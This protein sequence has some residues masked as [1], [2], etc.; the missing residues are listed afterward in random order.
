[1]R[2]LVSLNQSLSGFDAV[3]AVGANRGVATI[4]KKNDM[5]VSAIALDSLARVVLDFVGRRP[6]PIEAGHVPHQGFK[7]ELACSR[8]HRRTSCSIRRT[9][10]LRHN[11]SSVGNDLR[12]VGQLAYHAAARL[13]K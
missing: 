8:E 4:V 1:M 11:S 9:K 7:P 12:T 3:R 5:S 10:K 6:A 2:A 13:Q